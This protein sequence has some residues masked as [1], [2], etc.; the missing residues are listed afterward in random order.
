MRSLAHLCLPLLLVLF[1]GTCVRAQADIPVSYPADFITHFQD[2]HI[3]AAGVGF[4]AGTCGVLRR[5]TDSGQSWT[6][7]TSPTDENIES[8]A[9]APGGCAT[10]MLSTETGFFRLASNVWSPV[11]YPDFTS[12]GQLHWLTAN[13]V[14]HETGG[15]Y[16]DRSA[17]GGRTWTSIDFPGNSRGN[18][19]FSVANNIFVFIDNTLYRSTDNGATFTATSY[20]HPKTVLKQAWLDASRGWLFDS[21]RLFY[22]TTNGGTTWTLLNPTSQLTSVNW[23]I[24]LSA[25]HLV[26]AQVVNSRLESLDGG[27]TWTRN[28]FIPASTQRVNEKYHR[29]GNEIFTVGNQSQLLYSPQDFANFVE[30]AP[31]G[32][33]DRLEHLAFATNTLGYAINGNELLSTTDAGLTWTRT[34]MNQFGRD[35]H[36]LSNGA[37]IVLGSSGVQITTDRGASFTPFLPGAVVT[38]NNTPQRIG[39]KPNGDLYLMSGTFAYVTTNDGQSWTAIAHSLGYEPSAIF[40]LDQN[41]GYAVGRQSQFATT[42]NGGQTWTAGVGPANNS[43]DVYFTTPTNGWV[44]TASSRHV[45]TDGGMTWTSQNDQGGYDITRRASDGLLLTNRFASGNN[46]EVAVSRDNG[47]TWE[48]VA[49]NCYAFRAGALTPNGRYWFS[50][51]DGF[52]VRHDLDALLTSTRSPDRPAALALRAYPNPTGGEFTLELPELR[53]GGQ[54]QIEVF[55]GNGRR[56]VQHNVFTGQPRIAVDLAAFPAGVYFVRWTD[57]TRTG[58]VRMVKR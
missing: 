35:L 32:R 29:R 2:I 8:I 45:T 10:A 15:N 16:Y 31:F 20:T 36:A 53:T 30:L 54:G 39:V 33:L 49:Y 6:T 13:V 34:Q 4:A 51:G 50:G 47:V 25:T 9:C 21:D 14:I 55:D 1:A 19:D 43:V 26:G 18:M 5:T 40:F 37:A 11:D 57:G 46:G 42:T 38:D 3:D 7:V 56:V 22:R 41:R 24:A 27:V 52:I 28:E 17:D 12:N 58:R 23:F 44:S 48:A